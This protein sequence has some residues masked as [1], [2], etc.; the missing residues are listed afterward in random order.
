MLTL[1]WPNALVFYNVGQGGKN[2]NIKECLY[3]ESGQHLTE[4]P[5]VAGIR[6]KTGVG[7]AVSKLKPQPAHCW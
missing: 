3:L 1:L 6:A 5:E 4:Q 7:D 2:G